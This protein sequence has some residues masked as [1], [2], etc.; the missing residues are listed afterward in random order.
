MNSH[1]KHPGVQVGPRASLVS[2]RIFTFRHLTPLEMPPTPLSQL[3]G[4]GALGRLGSLPCTLQGAMLG[5][6]IPT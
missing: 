4:N 5:Y 1:D 2:A 6:V 3:S